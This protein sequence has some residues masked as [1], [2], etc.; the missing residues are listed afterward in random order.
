MITQK[1]EEKKQ[2]SFN[3]IHCTC[4]GKEDNYSFPSVLGCH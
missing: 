4:H 2:Q 1:P 3:N